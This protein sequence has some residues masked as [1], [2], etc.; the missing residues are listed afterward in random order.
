MQ[1]KLCMSYHQNVEQSYNIIVT[2][3]SFKTCSCNSNSTGKNCIHEE[4]KSRLNVQNLLLPIYLNMHK[5]FL[6]LVLYG[7]ETWSVTLREEYKLEGV[8]E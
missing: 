2:N 1:R 7:C 4:I 6:P 3:K 8:G 5:L